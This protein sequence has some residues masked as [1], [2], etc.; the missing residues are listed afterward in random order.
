M[1]KYKTV[2]GFRDI[3]NTEYKIGKYIKDI[4][5]EISESYNYKPIEL[6]EFEYTNLFLDFY[7]ENIKDTL[8]SIDNRYSTSISLRNNVV[9][10]VVRSIVE[11]KLYVDKSLPIKMMS[12]IVT[13]K[14]NKRHRKQK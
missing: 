2:K 1:T 13:Y 10:S 11:N 3:Y 12:N 7:G 8:Y 6:A 4:I 14:F 9:L 5:I